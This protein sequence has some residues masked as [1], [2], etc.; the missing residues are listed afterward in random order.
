[1]TSSTV[2]TVTLAQES[3][4]RRRWWSLPHRWRNPIGIVGLIIAVFVGSFF[5]EKLDLQT[6][7]GGL[8]VL[9]S[10]FLIVVRPILQRMKNNHEL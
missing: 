10:V 3:T 4:A 1:M 7:L 5:G 9:A 2:D 8:L 6:L